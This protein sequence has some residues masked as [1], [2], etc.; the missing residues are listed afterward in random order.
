MQVA[1]DA[2]ASQRQPHGSRSGGC[3]PAAFTYTKDGLVA[4]SL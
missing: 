1:A 4:L 3:R 2:T